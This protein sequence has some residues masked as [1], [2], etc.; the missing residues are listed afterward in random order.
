MCRQCSVFTS[1]HQVDIGKYLL[2]WTLSV[3]SSWVIVWTGK[4]SQGLHELVMS[5]KRLERAWEPHRSVAH[6]ISAE[7]SPGELPAPARPVV[8]QLGC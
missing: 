4:W 3:V 6:E 7:L 2:S 8:L 1:D 5:T